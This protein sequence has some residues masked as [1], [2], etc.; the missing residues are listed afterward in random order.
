MEEEKAGSVSLSTVSLEFCP[1][2]FSVLLGNG[3]HIHPLLGDEKYPMSQV[4]QNIFPQIHYY[5]VEP[6]TKSGLPRN[7][8][9]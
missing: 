5:H 9:E 7:L 4:Q 1:L 8:P 3:F 6:S 2:C